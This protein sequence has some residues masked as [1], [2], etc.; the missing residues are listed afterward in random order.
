VAAGAHANQQIT[1]AREADRGDDVG[2]TG[3]ADDAG[4]AAVD[5]AVPDRAGLVVA[6]VVGPITGPSTELRRRSLAT[7]VTTLAVSVAMRPRYGGWAST[8]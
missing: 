6:F 5:R 3:A 7:A 8:D 1:L 2:N 4:R